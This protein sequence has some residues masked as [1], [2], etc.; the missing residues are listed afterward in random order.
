MN[1]YV[2]TN[3]PTIQIIRTLNV[4]FIFFHILLKLFVKIICSHNLFILKKIISLQ[5][6]IY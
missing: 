5:V 1:F 6:L 2:N 4:L 3:L